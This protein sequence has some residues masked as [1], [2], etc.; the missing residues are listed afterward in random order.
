MESSYFWWLLQLI[1][2]SRL[3]ELGTKS[4]RTTRRKEIESVINLNYEYNYA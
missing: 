3:R 4:Q 1:M 2:S